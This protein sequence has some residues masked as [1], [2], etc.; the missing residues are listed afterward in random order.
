MKKILIYLIFICSILVT[1][2][3]G[4]EESATYIH[5]T[6]KLLLTL[7]PRKAD[8]VNPMVPRISAK[9]AFNL[10][11]EGKA[12]FFGAGQTKEGMIPGGI[13]MN[14]ELMENPPI[15]FL[16]KHEDK[17]IVIYCH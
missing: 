1:Y 2:S 6:F 11:I 10:Y 12:I 14:G 3:F 9:S 8:I 7:E 4:E 15:K 13:I 17:L 5:P 16:R